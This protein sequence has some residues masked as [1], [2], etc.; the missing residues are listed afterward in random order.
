MRAW[1]AG[2]TVN[3]IIRR[4]VKPLPIVNDIVSHLGAGQQGK[5]AHHFSP[6]VYHDMATADLNIFPKHIVTGIAIGPLEGV[7]IAAHDLARLVAKIEYGWQVGQCRF[8]N[9]VA[10]FCPNSK[11][12][13]S[14]TVMSTTWIKSTGLSLNCKPLTPALT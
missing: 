11:M 3:D 9:G 2:N 6:L 13:K 5:S 8:A 14:A 10:H 12:V 4:I 1:R 7:A